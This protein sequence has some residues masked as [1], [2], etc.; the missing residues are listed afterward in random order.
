M[1]LRTVPYKWQVAV[2]FVVGLFMDLLD[3]T[4]INTALPRLGEEFD[5]GTAT[6]EWVITGFLLSLA[7]WIPAS[8][9]LGDRFGTKRI[10]L[11]AL[12]VFTAGSALCGAAWSIESLIAFRVLQGIGGGMMTPVGTT[13]LF[14][15]FPP[16]ERAQASGALLIPAAVAPTIGPIV[17]GFLVDQASW[18]WIFYLN[19]PLGALTFVLAAV[20]LR[21]HQ[22]QPSGRLD[23]PGLFLSATGLPCLLYSLSRGPVVGWSSI[24]IVGPGI[25]GLALV[26]LLVV[27]ELRATDPLLDLRLLRDSHFRTVNIV[28]AA[29]IASVVGV[30]FLL[31]LQLQQ[32]RGLSA[33]ESGLTTFPQALGGI[34]VARFTSRLYP[35]LGPRPLLTLG[36]TGTAVVTILFFR[37]DLYTSLW[38]IRAAMFAR[39]LF[40]GV[41]IVAVQAA[42]FGTIPARS[43][44]RASALFS[45]NRQVSFS[46]GVALLATILT[47]R[48]S[49]HVSTAGGFGEEATRQAALAGFHDAFLVSAVIAALG[50][51]AALFVPSPVRD[52][53]H[54]RVTEAA[55]AH[56]DLE[57]AAS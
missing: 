15:A 39:G 46:L 17:G 20:L 29:A 40:V 21:E 34:A 47:E 3:T 55:P 27:V 38:W 35:K 6:L 2:I 54:P 26:G 41:A 11:L 33:F 18:R 7:V 24:E 52:R 12:A 23:L 16:E 56:A 19:L 10:F 48:T 28:Y 8:G 30:L 44:G 43:V 42:A 37:I 1:K 9:W 32:L 36:M 22:E 25:L 45:T 5:A 31:S 14:R 50:T 57:P 51:V 4:V 13:M 49:N 53:A